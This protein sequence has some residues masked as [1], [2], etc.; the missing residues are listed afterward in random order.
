MLAL[1]F[2]TA[3]PQAVR[4]Y[5]AVNN[6]VP[7]FRRGTLA[8]IFFLYFYFFFFSLYLE[9]N[10]ILIF[11]LCCFS[12]KIA[13]FE[14]FSFLLRNFF[15]FSVFMAWRFFLYFL[16]IISYYCGLKIYSNDAGCC[17]VLVLWLF[18]I[19]RLF[20][21]ELKTRSSNCIGPNIQHVFCVDFFFFCQEIQCE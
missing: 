18:S 20:S 19:F 10:K 3:A 17:W 4:W 7:F 14:S 5:K 12:F 21:V 9:L 6:S 2:R 11:M 1:G 8:T 16:F 13:T 15:P